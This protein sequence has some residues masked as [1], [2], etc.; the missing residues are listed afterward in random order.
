[1]TVSLALVKGRENIKSQLFKENLE[2]LP[3]QVRVVEKA[4]PSIIGNFPVLVDAMLGTGLKEAPR[5]PYA[6][7]IRELND[8]GG[9]IISVDVP[10]GLGT[11]L[12]VRPSLTISMHDVKDGMTKENSGEIVVVDIGIPEGAARFVGPGEFIYYPIPDRDSHK[13]QNGRLLIVGGGPYTGAPALSGLAAMAVGVD[14]LRIASPEWSASI[15]ASYSP[16][17]MVRPL[18]GEALSPGNISSISEL[19]EVSDALLIGPGLGR[20]KQTQKAVRQIVSASNIPVIIDADGLY[21]LLAKGMKPFRVPAVLTPHKKEFS[22]LAGIEPGQITDRGVAEMAQALGSTL[23][24]KG[25]VD[26]ITDG[27]RSKYNKTG[28][29]AMSVGGTGDVLAG[30][31]AGLMAKGVAAYDAARMGAYLSGAAGDIAFEKLGY[32]MTALDVVDYIP[33]VLMRSLPPV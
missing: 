22:R 16:N 30:I 7:W 12:A 29:P 27:E 1:W 10:S 17:F 13:G 20:D 5:E 15:I 3:E 25:Q 21:A 19:M 2:R 31:V 33:E 28:N 23:L 14:L 4:E 24:L 11:S 9:D 18:D 6:S 26:L 8:A 32:S